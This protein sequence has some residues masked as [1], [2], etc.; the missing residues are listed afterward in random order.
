M[1][2]VIWIHHLPKLSGLGSLL[3]ARNRLIWV[4]RW[5]VNERKIDFGIVERVFENEI[6]SDHRKL[7]L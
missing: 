3:N 5:H 4:W 6:Y 7:P 1:L 2:L